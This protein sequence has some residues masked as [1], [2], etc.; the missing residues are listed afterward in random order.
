MPRFRL[1]GSHVHPNGPAGRGAC[2]YHERG[3]E[4]IEE[5]GQRLVRSRVEEDQCH[6][7][8]V[9]ML[10]QRKQLPCQSSSTAV[11]ISIRFRSRSSRHTYRRT[12]THT[13]TPLPPSQTPT[14][15]PPPTH[16]HHLLLLSSRTFFA[17]AFSSGVPAISFRRSSSGSSPMRPSVSPAA[18][19]TRRWHV[20]S[21]RFD[22]SNR[23]DLRSSDLGDRAWAPSTAGTH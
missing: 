16:P 15:T 4:L 6:E 12:D 3:R 13:P 23:W 1:I 17:C 8:Q 22:T 14:P 9:V 10:D 18:C 2:A 7:Q 11:R 20:G 19:T 5:D 21:G